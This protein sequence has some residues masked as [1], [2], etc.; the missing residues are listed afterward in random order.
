M[1]L[2]WLPMTT[3]TPC[4]AEGFAIVEYMDYPE[5]DLATT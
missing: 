4:Q 3:A 1:L 2:M 5:L